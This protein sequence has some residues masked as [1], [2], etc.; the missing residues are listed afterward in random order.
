MFCVAVNERLKYSKHSNK[1][2]YNK[3]LKRDK[4]L[5]VA[6]DVVYNPNFLA[7]FLFLFLHFGFGPPRI[8]TASYTHRDNQSIASP[9]LFS[10]SSSFI[11]SFLVLK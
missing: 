5:F 2:D 4:Q 1:T 11:F 3:K 8:T 10:F 7:C 9:L 6:G